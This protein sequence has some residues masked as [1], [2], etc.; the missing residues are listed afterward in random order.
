M[1]DAAIIAAYISG[2]S[3]IISAGLTAWVSLKIAREK[4]APNRSNRTGISPQKTRR[5]RETLRKSLLGIFLVTG[6]ATVYFSAFPGDMPSM[7]GLGSQQVAGP[8]AIAPSPAPADP[9]SQ[10]VVEDATLRPNA[11]TCGELVMDALNSAAT[12]HLA[13]RDQLLEIRRRG[14]QAAALGAAC[15]K[16]D[17]MVASALSTAHGSAAAREHAVGDTLGCK[18]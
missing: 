9:T 15:N 10:Q 8:A 6:G 17:A 11:A 1:P 7:A 5:R 18:N 14:C 4:D 12:D 16:V 3:S 13:F 2:G